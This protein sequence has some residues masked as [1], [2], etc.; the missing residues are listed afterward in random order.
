MHCS[1]IPRPTRAADSVSGIHKFTQKRWMEEAPTDVANPGW[2]CMAYDMTWHDM[3]WHHKLTMTESIV[4]V[5][6]HKFGDNAGR[7]SWRLRAYCSNWNKC[8]FKWHLQTIWCFHGGDYEECRLLRYKNLVR[9][10]HEIHYFSA[11]EPSRLMLR[12][13][14][15]FHVGDYKTAVFWDE[16]PCG[17]WKN[18]R[19]GG[20]Y[21]LHHLGEKNRRAR[22][23]VST[24]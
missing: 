1:C 17:S 12:K 2:I 11:T 15:G 19:F 3:T 16:E 6:G 7:R 5:C 21:R 23:N 13:I 14:W 18:R 22:N 24:I 9:T 10:S 20:T 8:N 4:Q